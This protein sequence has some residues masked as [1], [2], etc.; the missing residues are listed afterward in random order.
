[1]TGWF[2]NVE[3]PKYLTML[4]CSIL[5]T[6]ACRWARW[7]TS[8]RSAASA[9]LLSGTLMTTRLLFSARSS[10]R[11]VLPKPPRPS[12]LISLKRSMDAPVPI[13]QQLVVVRQNR[14]DIVFSA[15]PV[16][17]IDRFPATAFNIRPAAGD[18]G[19]ELGILH[20]IGQTVGAEQQVIAG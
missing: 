19:A 11:S 9:S 5:S 20:H 3:C 15:V 8:S 1:M 16:G 13:L 4:G 12:S 10:T 6:L 18:E 17:P 2:S 14:R 7:I